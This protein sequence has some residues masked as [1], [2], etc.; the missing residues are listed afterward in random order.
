MSGARALLMAVLAV[1]TACTGGGASDDWQATI[2]AARTVAV[3][4]T[5]VVPSDSTPAATPTRRPTRTPTPAQPPTAPPTATIAEPTP[6]QTTSATP[7]PDRGNFIGCAGLSLLLSTYHIAPSMQQQAIGMIQVGLDPLC[8]SLIPTIIAEG[9]VEPTPTPTA[10]PVPSF[11]WLTAG[12]LQTIRS[13]LALA[14]LADGT[15][16]AIGGFTTFSVPTQ[17]ADRYDPATRTWSPAPLMNT[18]RFDA[19]TIRLL[20]GRVLVTGGRTATVG[21]IL[22]HAEVFD[23]AQNA[24]IDLAE[25]AGASGRMTRPR[26]R[27]TMTLL[28]DGRVLIVG[29]Q[30]GTGAERSAEIFDP[31]ISTFSPISGPD[32]ARESH[33][34]TKLSDGRVLI[35]GGA[36]N[37]QQVEVFD[38]VSETFTTIGILLATHTGHTAIP[39]SGDRV[40][41][42][43]GSPQSPPKAD[44][45]SVGDGTATSITIDS[46]A[47]AA[48]GSFFLPDGRLLLLGVVTSHVSVDALE[49]GATLG[50]SSFDTTP[51]ALPGAAWV[52]LDSG[53]ILMAGS[54]STANAHRFI[55]DA[56]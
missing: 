5:P 21:G 43:G 15:V 49:P 41:I 17:V 56:P 27:H 36:G 16:L 8:D 32:G 55:L 26:V 22:D 10:T 12:Q 38:P 25:R 51:L 7:T 23:P 30:I 40:L 37:V 11:R 28:D 42:L 29:G 39:L 45:F 4:R 24:W 33:S 2:D 52:Q 35:A 18:A 48:R 47:N 46:I 19:S 44:L 9:I 13:Q 3:T 6:T 53:E 50:S 1:L 54:G 34:A 20:D 31:D 14:K